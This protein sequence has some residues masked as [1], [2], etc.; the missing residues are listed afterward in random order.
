MASQ[1]STRVQDHTSSPSRL[2]YSRFVQL[3][4]VPDERVESRDPPPAPVQE[5]HIDLAEVVL[6][7]F[8]GEAR[9]RRI[10]GLD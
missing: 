5:A 4:L 1:R 9:R 8:P 2:R 3:S 10:D 6:R 7:G